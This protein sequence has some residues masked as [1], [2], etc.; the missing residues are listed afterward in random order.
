MP[1]PRR[2]P[3]PPEEPSTQL[4]QVTRELPSQRR[5]VVVHDRRLLYSMLE[6]KLQRLRSEVKELEGLKKRHEEQG[7]DVE[8]QV[9]NEHEVPPLPNPF[10]RVGEVMARRYNMFPA[11]TII[12][13]PDYRFVVGKTDKET[14]QNKKKAMESVKVFLSE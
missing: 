1:R 7:E 11:G 2:P 4:V 9:V 8:P 10:I 13:N 12:R 6:L 3:P 14:M 5:T